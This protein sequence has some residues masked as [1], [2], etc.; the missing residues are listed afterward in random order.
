[1]SV[2]TTYTQ[3][4]AIA[5]EGQ[6]ADEQQS[7]VII[8]MR[9]NEATAEMA[10]GLAV[11]FEGSTDDQGALAPDAITEDVAGIVI[12]SHAYERGENGTLGE[13]GVKPGGTL[14]VLRKGRIWVKPETS[15]SP[16][17]RLH[18][19]AVALGTERE[20]AVRA[21]ADSTDTIDSTNQGVFLTSADANGLALL[22]VDFTSSPTVA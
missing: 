17:D 8:S 11:V 9:N 19:R 10:F 13:T 20:G 14:N 2:Q 3:D 18:I 1:M 6:L 22:E 21:S 4:P 5:L 12:H 15:V 7:P 16:G